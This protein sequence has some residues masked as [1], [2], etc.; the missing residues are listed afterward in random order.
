MYCT[1]CRVTGRE[2]RR[3]WGRAGH[4]E[5]KGIKRRVGCH[6]RSAT[7]RAH[8]PHKH[9]HI[10][11][12]TEQTRPWEAADEVHSLTQHTL[13]SC[14]RDRVGGVKKFLRLATKNVNNFFRQTTANDLTYPVIRGGPHVRRWPNAMCEMWCAMS[15]FPFWTQ[16][17]SAK[18]G[19]EN[20]RILR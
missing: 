4:R 2:T 16:K 14:P 8:S 7:C 6:A 13:S 12:F 11:P 9:W 15:L 20:F 5:E 19:S 3:V 1:R 10:Q 17:N 18:K